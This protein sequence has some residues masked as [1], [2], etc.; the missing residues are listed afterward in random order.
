[1]LLKDIYFCCSIYQKKPYKNWC[2][3]SR[4]IAILTLCPIIL[5]HTLFTCLCIRVSAVQLENGKKFQISDCIFSSSMF[6]FPALLSAN[7]IFSA[8]HYRQC[9]AESVAGDSTV[10]EEDHARFLQRLFLDA[11]QPGADIRKE[12]FITPYGLTANV[13]R[14]FLQVFFISTVVTVKSK[15]SN[16]FCPRGCV[17]FRMSTAGSVICLKGDFLLLL[18]R[19]PGFKREILSEMGRLRICARYLHCR[20]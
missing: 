3:E 5:Q 17:T 8:L 4:D 9:L 20:L 11:D 14:T 12:I 10:S 2:L 19:N 1:M 7:L 13:V 15:G 18:H 16:K 6:S